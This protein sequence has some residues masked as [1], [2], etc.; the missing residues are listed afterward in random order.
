M[1]KNLVYLAAVALMTSGMAIAQSSSQGTGT[2]DSQT[3]SSTSSAPQTGS[4]TDTQGDVP[5]AKEGEPQSGKDSQA[6]P[7]EERPGAMGTPET[8]N[9]GST[10]KGETPATGAQTE[11]KGTTDDNNTRP[12]TTAPSDQ[13]N[14]N[15]TTPKNNMSS[16]SDPAKVPSYAKPIDS[17]APSTP[18]T[19]SQQGTATGTASPDK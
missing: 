13:G 14:T 1:K 18:N 17:T 3:G 6:N 11:R 4:H 9:A 5:A 8:P 12:G 16:G 2:M 7:N 15:S 19:P 10:P